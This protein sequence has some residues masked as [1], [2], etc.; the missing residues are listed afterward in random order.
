MNIKAWVL[1]ASA[2]LWL[3]PGLAEENTPVIPAAP[4]AASTGFIEAEALKANLSNGFGDWRDF[5]LRGGVQ[6]GAHLLRGELSA[7][8]HFDTDGK[9]AGVM[10]TW[11]INPDWYGSLAVG[12]GDGAFFLPRYRVD[13]FI[14]KKWLPSRQLVTSLGAGYYR[15]PD[16]HIDR[17]LT[18]GLIYYFDAPWV[19]E[20]GVRFN[21]SAPG[22]VDST[23]KFVAATYG[24]S[25]ANLVVARVAW[26]SEGYQAIGPAS[27]IVGFNS[28]ER[29]LAWRHWFTRHSGVMLRAE[30]YHNPIYRRTGVAA[31]LFHEFD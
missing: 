27:S 2:W 16:H 21:R 7:Q 17:S 3:V 10:D 29:S 23:Q 8:R 14:N 15:A 26:G 25:G 28:G 18:A 13:A 24:R 11:T 6:R 4:A 19:V 22:A 20:G 1:G 30:R 5:T 12:A 9:Y 31:N